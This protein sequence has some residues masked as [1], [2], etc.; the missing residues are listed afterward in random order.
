MTF[1]LWTAVVVAAFTTLV[2]ELELEL[3]E[4]PQPAI[5][6]AA[7]IATNNARLIGPTPSVVAL[8]SPTPG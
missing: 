3:P 8:D 7:A 1:F 4:L 5:P 6:T 2:V